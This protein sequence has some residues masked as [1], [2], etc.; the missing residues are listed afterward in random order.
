[1]SI[2]K[3]SSFIVFGKNYMNTAHSYFVYGRIGDT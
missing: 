2:S 1:M 3:I